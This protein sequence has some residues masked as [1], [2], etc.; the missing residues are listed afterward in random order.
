MGLDS[1]KIMCLV[2]TRPEAIKMAPVIKLLK[3]QTWAD[4][5]VVFSGQHQDLVISTLGH[6][7]IEP[8]IYCENLEKNISLAKLTTSLIER[9]DKVI[10]E[11]SPDILLVQ[12]D[13]TSVMT[14]SI[15]SLYH[16]V[17]LGHIEAGLRTHDLHQP[18][19]EE[20][21]RRVA[22]VVSDWHFAP[23]DVSKQNLL[24]ENVPENTIHVTGNT[25]IDA[26]YHT[27]EKV[28]KA[29]HETNNIRVLATIHRRENF[30]EP[31]IDICE[32]ISTLVDNNPTMIVDIPVHPNP[33]VREYIY[34]TLGPMEQINLLEPLDYPEFCQ[35]LNNAYLILSDSGG[36][37]EEAPALGKPVLVLRNT[38]E[39][40]DALA[41]NCVKLVGHDKQL[42]IDTAQKLIDDQSFY[43]SMSNTVSPYGDGK[44]SG[45][46]VDI[47]KLSLEL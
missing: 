24:L 31:L 9:L 16:K 25:V 41:Y 6:F 47:I 7:G 2:G 42:I 40:P 27:L 33:N 5:Q 11:E 21:N 4:T 43:Q 46:I 15:L 38:T 14:A 22:S 19:P 44:A 28:D 20:F 12:G 3:E 18:F 36:V 17:K 39:R 8:D 26:L 45:R 32:A 23:T 37:Q 1:V 34:K 10:S 35:Y 13:T 29:N 30:G